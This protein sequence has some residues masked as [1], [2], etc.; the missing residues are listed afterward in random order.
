MNSLTYCSEMVKILVL[1][2][3]FNVVMNYVWTNIRNEMKKKE[4]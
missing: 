3:L 1:L 2:V 4:M